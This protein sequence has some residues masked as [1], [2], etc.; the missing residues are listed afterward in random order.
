MLDGID[1]ANAGSYQKIVDILALTRMPRPSTLHEFAAIV[2]RRE[3]ERVVGPIAI[4]AQSAT[5]QR[6]ANAFAML[7]RVERLIR[8][9]P[10]REEARRWLGSFYAFEREALVGA[11]D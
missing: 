1:A 10:N 2:R 9:I 8:V 7:A 3:S 5:A 11:S 4:V 6:Y